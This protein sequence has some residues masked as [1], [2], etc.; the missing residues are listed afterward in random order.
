M[1]IK[2]YGEHWR[3]DFVEWGK[4]GRGRGGKLMGKLSKKDS[5]H[6][7]DHWDQSGIYV[8][9]QDREAVYV[10]QASQ[11]DLGSRLRNHLTDRLGGRWNAFSWYGVRGVDLDKNQLMPA[12]DKAASPKGVID[13]LEAI[14][15]SAGEPRL[16]KR[17][18]QPGADVLNFEQ[19]VPE[20]LAVSIGEKS[21]QAILDLTEKVAKIQQQIDGKAVSTSSGIIRPTPPPVSAPRG[22]RKRGRPPKS[23]EL[24]SPPA[25]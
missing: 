11:N 18:G 7:V 5:T 6:R 25:S 22:G 10:G 19:D 3:P 17:S 8:L 4:K 14:L 23:R 13:E 21:Y 20:D 24:Q 16:N 2:V 9:Y 12:E 15:I 1:L